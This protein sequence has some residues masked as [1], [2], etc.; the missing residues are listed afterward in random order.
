[1]STFPYDLLRRWPDVEAPDLFAIDGADRLL[2]TEIDA[3][4][5]GYGPAPLTEL[6]VVG[7]THG[8]LTLGV[9][10][11]DEPTGITRVRVHQ[12]A[13]SGELALENN[14]T[15]LAGALAFVAHEAEQPHA[16]AHFVH[17]AL[18]AALVTD[19]HL[20]ALRLPRSLEQLDQ[21]AALIAAYAADDVFVLAGGRIK[22]M[23]HSMNEVLARYFD[24]VQASLAEQKSRVLRASG[25]KREEA[26]EALAGYPMT[27]HHPQQDLTVCA[28]GGVF[29]GINV[30][31]GT[32]AM[33]EVLGQIPVSAGARVIDFGCGT[34]I[35]AAILAR[36]HP[37][38]TIIASDQSA[39]AVASAQATM[40]ANGLDA[41][42]TVV[43][44]DGLSQQPDASADVIVFNP[45]F[46]AG[47]AVHADTSLHLFAEAGRVLKPGGEL[48][49]VANRHLGYK[50]SL[51]KVVGE[52]TEVHH[53]Q[54]FTVTRS[55]KGA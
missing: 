4:L 8:A 26:L 2:L 21:W 34:G 33:L 10:R 38:A 29:A 44:D 20:V 42:V 43:R 36:L 49:I 17:C 31:I 39:A 6:V 51:R 27:K 52:T 3:A 37:T 14:A 1:M 18:D 47:A 23:T 25:P 55:I 30:D 11:K 48:W 53:T 46:H 13:R 12:D 35:F 7:D 19:A 41:R 24:T 45:P 28:Q 15:A 5:D 22:H 9:L 50:A 54:K 16:S 32:R 40:A